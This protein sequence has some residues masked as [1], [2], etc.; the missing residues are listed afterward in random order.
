MRR[1]KTWIAPLAATLTLMVPAVASAQGGVAPGAPGASANWTTGNKQG[2]GTSVGARSK[3]WYTLSGGALSEVYFPRGDSA[4]VRSLE[5]AVTDGA[6]FVVRESEDT[7]HAVRLADSRSLTYEQVN[8]AKSGR[9]R[10]TKTYVTDP[11]RETV[12]MRVR[13]EALTPGDYRLFVLYDPAL[14]NSSRHDSAS[15]HGAGRDVALLAGEGAV[16]SALVASSGFAR[17]SSGFVGVSDGWTDLEDDRQMDWSYDSAPDGNVLQTGEVPVEGAV[18]T[19]TLALGFADSPTAAESTALTSLAKF[20]LARLGR[21][22]RSVRA[23]ARFRVRGR[24]TNLAGRRAGTGRLTF[25]LRR[26]R[27]ARRGWYVPAA[28]MAGDRNKGQNVRL[29]KGG[30]S[31]RFSLRLRVP[32]TVPAGRYVFRGCVRGAAGRGPA[33]AARV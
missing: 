24:V 30:R 10:L 15:R 12:L 33:A 16:A 2:L 17:T 7:D 28:G 4:N 1:R 21:V 13:F 32:G 23:G 14:G 26:S 9:Y 3:V 20:R 31:R 19:F 27:K 5:F 22:P 6:S 11:E 29:T 8:T 25:S 18:T